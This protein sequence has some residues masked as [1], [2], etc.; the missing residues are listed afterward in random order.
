MTAPERIRHWVERQFQPHL[1]EQVTADLID[2][3]AGNRAGN[4]FEK[5]CVARALHFRMETLAEGPFENREQAEAFG[6]AE[7]GVFW[8]VAYRRDGYVIKVKRY[9]E[10]EQ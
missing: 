2:V 1:V 6:E 4:N 3:A 5:E 7:V 9:E 8:Y 10:G